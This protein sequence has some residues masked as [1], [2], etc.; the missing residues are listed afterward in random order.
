MKEIERQSIELDL[1]QAKINPHFLYNNLSAINWLALDCGQD[2]IY[3]ITTEMATFY[4][5]A[6]NRGK[7]VDRLSVEIANIRSYVNLL[8]ISHENSFDIEYDIEEGLLDDII[9]I[10]ILQP[11]VENAVEHGIDQLRAKRGILRISGYTEGGYLVLSVFD[12]GTALYDKSG[13]GAMQISEYGYGT[14]NVHR[15]IQILCG[16]D[17]GLTVSADEEGTTASIK[18]KEIRAIEILSKKES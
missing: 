5:T 10:F 9:P 18:L 3:E 17:C 1:L 2:R 14:S 16:E 13:K 15:R 11:L 7:N 4:R 12:N 8:Q 6:L